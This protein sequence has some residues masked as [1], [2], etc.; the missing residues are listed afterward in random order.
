MGGDFSPGCWAAGVRGGTPEGARERGREGTAI[1]RHQ[2]AG[3]A[4]LG[5]ERDE[6]TKGRCQGPGVDTRAG[7]SR[8]SG[9]DPLWALEMESDSPKSKP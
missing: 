5:T 8:V 2:A 6:A 4:L 1:R 7:H 3:R 9:W